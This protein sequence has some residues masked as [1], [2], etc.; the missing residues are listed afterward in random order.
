MRLKGELCAKANARHL[1]RTMSL[2]EVLLWSELRKKPNGVQFRRQH[3]AGGFVL[4]FFCAT[5]N[6]AIEVD[7]EAH[8]RG[9]RPAKDLARDEWLRSKGVEVMRI[10]AVD[11]LRNLD[12]VLQAIGFAVA[13]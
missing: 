6:L 7:G 11:V 8:N 9:S 5:A 1:R 10:P 12:G 2:P 4:D 13:R 3:P